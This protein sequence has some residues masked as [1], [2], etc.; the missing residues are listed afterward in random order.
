[1]NRNDDADSKDGELGE[2]TCPEKNRLTTRE[3]ILKTV[4][5]VII[6]GGAILP[7][8]SGGVLCV[9]FGIYRPLMEVLADPLKKLKKYLWLL[10][11]VVIGWLIG[12]FGF[13]NVIE[14]MFS[15]SEVITIWVFTGLIAGTF[16]SLI[17]EAGSKGRSRGSFLGLIIG[18]V[19]LFS[20]LIL[21]QYRISAEI[22]A[23]WGW[24]LFC[25]VLWGLSLVVPGMTS[26]SI[27][28]SLGLFQPMTEGMA[29]FD[30]G[31]IIP[32]LIGI[33][34]VV[35]L[36]AKLVNYLFER[37]YSTA[38]HTIIGIVAASTLSIIP[39]R[40]AGVMEFILCIIFG[41]IAFFAAGMLENYG[42]KNSKKP[43]KKEKN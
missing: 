33:I 13:A 18:F 5:G 21:I 24:F 8:I 1:M 9:V 29:S 41:T 40:Y 31:V 20:F 22:K 28:I 27:L 19:L 6:G 3:W 11:P 12:F 43:T 2:A 36:S 15:K 23:N 10:L 14:W 26:S 4:Q 42:N 17:R 16:P 39:L 37:Y 34:I 30:F 32:M 35:L 7:G 25:G 38:Y